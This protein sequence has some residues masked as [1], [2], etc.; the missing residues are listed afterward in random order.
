MRQ[1]IVEFQSNYNL[2]KLEYIKFKT[3]NPPMAYYRANLMKGDH[4]FI[5]IYE[6]KEIN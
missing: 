2:G 4:S 1:Y 6:I 5:K 3:D